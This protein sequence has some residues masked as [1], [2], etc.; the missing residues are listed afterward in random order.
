MQIPT[1]I[2]GG[3]GGFGGTT[4][5]QRGYKVSAGSGLNFST[6][7]FKKKKSL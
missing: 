3:L 5:M 4:L 2:W 6:E 7:S 1:P